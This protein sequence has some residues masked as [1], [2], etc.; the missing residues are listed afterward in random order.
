VCGI[1]AEESLYGCGIAYTIT[2]AGSIRCETSTLLCFLPNFLYDELVWE[3]WKT[4]SQN[5][6][7]FYA[8]LM[9]DN[10]ELQARISFCLVLPT[11]SSFCQVTALII[12]KLAPLWFIAPV[13][14]SPVSLILVSCCFSWIF[15]EEEFAYPKKNFTSLS[16]VNLILVSCCFSW[17]FLEEEFAYPKKNFTSLS[18]RFVI[19]FDW[20][21]LNISECN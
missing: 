7:L 8:L 14:H 20:D 9:L 19:Y 16:M 6:E 10:F 13:V 21:A 2:S 4:C 17:I 5:L 18:L 1:F 11:T 12:R 15:L 3:T